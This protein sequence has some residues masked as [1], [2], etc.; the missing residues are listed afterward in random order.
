MQGVELT[1]GL[2]IALV[3]IAV[4]VAFGWMLTLAGRLAHPGPIVVSLSLLTAIAL[5]GGIVTGSGEVLTLAATGMGALAG[6]LAAI[7]RTE[8]PRGDNGP[9]NDNKEEE[10]D[11]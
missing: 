4:V 1:A 2:V 5:I 9:V 11:A 10:P 6:S 3:A 8:A 7:Y